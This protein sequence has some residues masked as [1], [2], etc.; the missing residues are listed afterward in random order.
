MKPIL[1]LLICTSSQ[2]A[3]HTVAQM[4]QEK[5]TESISVYCR[6]YAIEGILNNRRGKNVRQSNR[7]GPRGITS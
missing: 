6:I 5:G 4:W 1:L 3:M 7:K 2:L